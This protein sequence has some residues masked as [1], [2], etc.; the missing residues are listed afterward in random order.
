MGDVEI[1]VPYLLVARIDH[2]HFLG[3]LQHVK[4]LEPEQYESGNA[5]RSAARARRKRDLS[6]EHFVI[7]LLHPLFHPRLQIRIAEVADPIGRLGAGVVANIRM[8]GIGAQR[9]G[10]ARNRNEFA[11]E[12]EPADLARREIGR[13]CLLLRLRDPSARPSPRGNCRVN[14]AAQGATREKPLAVR[15]CGH[16]PSPVR[17]SLL[18]Q[19][20]NEM[21]RR[22]DSI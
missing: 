15:D 22:G 7:V 2:H 1:D 11:A 20:V 12:G 14:E 19:I 9:T 17:C 18:L 16:P 5:R 3:R 6:G 4:R 21:S 8:S 13:Q 10:P